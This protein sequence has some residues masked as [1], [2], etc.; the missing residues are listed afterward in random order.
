MI[1]QFL[2]PETLS[3]IEF[4]ATM[5]LG[6]WVKDLAVSLAT[7]FSFWIDK[8]FN[9]GDTVYIDGK[10][11]IIVA[12]GLRQTIFQIEDERG[13]TWRYVF[14]ARIKTLRLEKVVRE[15]EE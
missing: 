6:F 15:K 14:N 7:G 9:V 5:I 13:I 8:A 2:T 3:L 11:A 10:K 12:I 1:E 4:V